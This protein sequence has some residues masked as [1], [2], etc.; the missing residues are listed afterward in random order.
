[1]FNIAR[2]RYYRKKLDRTITR[3]TCDCHS[4]LEFGCCF[5]DRLA[6]TCCSVK[7]GVEVHLP[8]VQEAAKRYPHQ[9][10]VH[11]NML[12]VPAL[13]LLISGIDCVL[14]IDVI[15]HLERDDAERM[16]L[17]AQDIARK[18]VL[19]FTPQGDMPQGDDPH[20]MGA[21]SWQTHRSA[22]QVEDLEKFDFDVA[23]WHKCHRIRGNTYSAMF[24]TWE[25][26]VE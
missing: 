25:P 16:I 1:M 17:Y 13:R 8:Y 21:D 15:E 24:A 5:G 10:Y 4:A 7:I 11:A 23:V 2:A 26:K 6:A 14:L 19:L 22:F 12:D 9:I 20:E 18:R 3:M